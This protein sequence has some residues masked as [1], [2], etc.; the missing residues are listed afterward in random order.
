M[1]KKLNRY[2]KKEIIQR[3]SNGETLDSLAN[4][5]GYTKLT[6]SRNIKKIIGSNLFNN[7][8]KSINN[9]DNNN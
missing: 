6:I 5:F 1:P 9:S 8:N 7:L 4:K 3:F 2:T